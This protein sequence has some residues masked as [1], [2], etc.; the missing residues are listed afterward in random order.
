M[1]RR[2]APWSRN[3]G[4]QGSKLSEFTGSQQQCS[5]RGHCSAEAP[6]SGIDGTAGN[7][8]ECKR[9]GFQMEPKPLQ[10]A[11]LA[12]GSSAHPARVT[13]LNSSVRDSSAKVTAF[14]QFEKGPSATVIVQDGP[15][16]SKK[17]KRESERER[18]SCQRAGSGRLVSSCDTVL[19]RFSFGQ[20]WCL[21][22]LASGGDNP[23]VAL[24]SG[25]AFPHDNKT[26]SDRWRSNSKSR[27]PRA[28]Q[29]CGSDT[30]YKWAPLQ[31]RS[32][33]RRQKVG[34][35]RPTRRSGW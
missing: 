29:Q 30:W 8:A 13:V 4:T 15:W 27:L 5:L 18:D 12:S 32:T 25:T 33:A 9:G 6:E 19:R 10:M 26:S 23:R 14:E 31:S 3:D 16:K 24:K 17:N 34:T 7:T 2:R 20:Y 35:W 28:S 11:E 22:G 21:S 1:F